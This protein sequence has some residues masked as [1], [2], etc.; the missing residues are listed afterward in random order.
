M[1]F[2]RNFCSLPP[3][4][5]VSLLLAGCSGDSPERL[6]TSAR[7]YLEKNDSKAAVIQVK[8]A[9]QQNPDIPEARFLLGK[10][11][12]AGGDADGAEVE[13]RK[14]MAL[15][16]PADE[17]TPLLA[18][19][20]MMRGQYKKLVAEF[21]EARVATAEGNAE[22]Q[23]AIAVAYAALGNDAGAERALAAAL[24]S[25]PD[26]A[27][28]LLVRARQSA[29]RGEFPSAL[30]IVD[31][32]LAK[33]P[34]N[35]EALKARGDL[36]MAMRETDQALDDY[37][38]AVLARP[39]FVL[40]HAAI[41]SVLLSQHKLDEAG[42]QVEQLRQVAPGHPTTTLLEGRLAF[43]NK[44][45]PKAR[46]LAQQVLATAPDNPAALQLAGSVEFQL[47]SFMQ[48]EIHFTK[49]VRMYPDNL[50]AHR[51]LALTY[52]RLGQPG[53]A[54]LVIEPVLGQIGDNSNML[55]LAGEVAMQ[56]GEIAQAEAYFAKASALDPGNLQKKT[57]VA[58]TQV[59]K[60][61]ASAFSELEQ[62]ASTDEGTQADMAL[63][64][65]SIQRRRFDTAMK[66]IDALDRKQPGSP[67]TH[68][69]RGVVL[70][71]KKDGAGARRSFERA[72]AIAPSYFP[73]AAALA[74]S[75][76][77][78]NRFEEARKRFEAVLAADPQSVQALLALA[79]LKLRAGGRPEEVAA[80]LNEAIA[81]NPSAPGPRM[82]LIDFHWRNKD[83][84]KTLSSAQDAVAALPER[85]EFLDALGRAQLA[86]GDTSQALASFNRFAA[87]QPDS[88]LPLLRIA[89]AQAAAKDSDAA[90]QN[91]NKALAIKPDLLEAQRGLIGLHVAKGAMEQAIAVARSVQRQRPKEAIG[92][93]LEGDARSR[94]KAWADAAGAY[95]SGLKH[96]PETELATRL[97]TVLLADDRQA[98]ADRLAASWLKDHPQDVA[99]R[100]YLGGIA[101]ATGNLDAAGGHY[102]AVVDLQPD[103]AVA[104]NNLAWVSFQQKSPKALEYA[105]KANRLAPGNPA[106][107]D[108]LAIIVLQKGNAA[109][110]VDLLRK[111][112]AGAPQS[113]EIRVNYALALIKSGDK[114]AA[115]KEVDALTQLGDKGPRKEILDRL[116]AEL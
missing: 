74:S 27:P 24:Q 20:M 114:E 72:L 80:L 63:I 112:V 67:Q 103:N 30:G 12:L 57:A 88:P 15:K 52:L 32:V 107:M 93:L 23:S 40:A 41:V 95:R 65:A 89:E 34:A 90:I 101:V 100:M 2:L 108:T 8:N 37:R 83:V 44:D 25:K 13:L 105:E 56:N 14:A 86:S 53:R 91:L 111:A 109:R 99:F 19:A 102:R 1:D 16:H 78:E 69:L 46:R 85:T 17:T 60:G 113:L 75:D 87:A 77:A 97:H 96:A 94:A 39:D 18:Q 35:A 11:L 9:L 116:N 48:A 115:R 22:L 29:S 10:A 59:A 92:Y 49:L 4:L 5:L 104:L 54:K 71:G 28:A 68:H 70:A 42:K 84:K 6:L 106:F 36:L 110:A 58:L 51:L 82:A 50:D 3:F 33:E 73:S 81:A 66:A 61:S 45:L 98:D 43:V 76:L 26:H 64:A 21:S 31:S 55:A 47:Q 79:E 7:D 62:L 38:K